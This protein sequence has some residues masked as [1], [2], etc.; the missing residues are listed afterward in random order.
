MN[1]AHA[2]MH[3]DPV[4]RLLWSSEMNPVDVTDRVARTAGV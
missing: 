1:P 2:A 3:E 4:V